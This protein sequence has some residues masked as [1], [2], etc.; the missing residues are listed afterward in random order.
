MNSIR[1]NR[2]LVSFEAFSSELAERVHRPLLRSKRGKHLS[3]HDSTTLLVASEVLSYLLHQLDEKGRDVESVLGATSADKLEEVYG[4]LL[5]EFPDS[6]LLQERDSRKMKFTKISEAT[7]EEYGL[8]YSLP[9]VQKLLGE[10]E[11][12]LMTRVEYTAFLTAVRIPE[13]KSRHFVLRLLL[14]KLAPQKLEVLKLLIGVL[15]RV[16]VEDDGRGNEIGDVIEKCGRAIFQSNEVSSDRTIINRSDI[17]AAEQCLK[18]LLEEGQILRHEGEGRLGKF[19]QTTGVEDVTRNPSRR[20]GEQ[21][22]RLRRRRSFGGSPKSYSAIHMKREQRVV[23]ARRDAG[24]L[25]RCRG[26][27]SCLARYVRACIS[28]SWA[29]G[30]TLSVSTAST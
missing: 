28:S 12:A 23:E 17:L 30:C 15:Q 18:M 2:K 10:L 20:P 19:R 27:T 1:M 29:V 24:R 16:S 22:S 11:D 7:F 14:D 6:G 13:N 5:G 9:L 25:S 3:S 4:I 21:P 8:H 26:S